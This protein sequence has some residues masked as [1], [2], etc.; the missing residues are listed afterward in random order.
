MFITGLT[1]A[2]YT[3]PAK[4]TL[5]AVE[6]E[7]STANAASTNGRVILAGKS[8]SIQPVFY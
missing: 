6:V 2:R 3:M 4:N 8:V 1:Q 5:T 7:L